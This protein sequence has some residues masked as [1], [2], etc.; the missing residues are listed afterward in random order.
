MSTKKYLAV[1]DQ[2][3][4]VVKKKQYT[5]LNSFLFLYSFTKGERKKLAISIALLIAFS[6]VAMYSGHAMGVL[7]G[8]GLAKKNWD[9]SL[10]F[11]VIVIISELLSLTF[12]Y[13]G[14]KILVNSSGRVILTIRE[15]LFKKLPKLPMTFY[16]RWPRGRVVTRLTHDVEGVES[17]FS[18]SLGRVLNS[19]FLAVS[20]M[21]AMLLTDTYLGS[22]LIIS[23][24]PAIA[25]VYFTRNYVDSLNRTMSKYSSQ[26]NS[27]LSEFIDGLYVIRSFGLEGWSYNIFKD[28]VA[29]HV[30]A[31][32]K[33]NR[34]YSFTN[35]MI[36]F[37]CG[38]PLILL[39]YF[40]GDLVLEGKMSLALFVAFL[41]YSE[42]FFNPVMMLFREVHVILQ[43]FTSAQRVANFLREEDED[44]YFKRDAVYKGHAIKGDIEF[45]N[46]W[47]S[48][49]EDDW[50]LRDVSFKV[51]QGQK[52]GIVGTTGSGKSTTISVLA[53]LY[54]FQKGEVLIDGKSLKDWDIDNI[55]EQIGLVSQDVILFQGSLR[56]NLT[57]DPSI[58]DEKIL[59][60]AS[61]T[62][63]KT[64]MD[65]A[66]I[67]LDSFVNDGGVNLSAGEKQVISLTRICLLNP[68]ILILDEATANV[69][70][71]YEQILH[72][73]IEKVM[74]GKTSFIIAHRLETI[75]ECDSLLVFDKGEL[76]EHG[77]PEELIASQGIFYGLS[78]ASHKSVT[79]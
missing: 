4:S 61:L 18:G 37:L 43:A 12:N 6:S 63:L 41:R 14:R 69:D 50:S 38:L 65:K 26:I 33:S 10:R 34:F 74:E 36:S 49:S 77:A 79:Q 66:S 68:H 3:E 48:Y 2:D 27:K 72:E 15:A 22:I 58:S 20:S 71:Y 7:V 52:I 78:K 46:V 19:G 39:V 44:S 40:G 5:A 11:A 47:M 1:D 9:L 30:N 24:L 23:M 51:N 75:K 35:P 64:V 28:T 25:L 57:V 70:P 29:K 17:F 31:T 60:I 67:T 54:D 42:R 55:R 16:D 76:V 73:G 59:E 56:D 21:V 45:K 53:R 62:G 13:F 8:D 32:L